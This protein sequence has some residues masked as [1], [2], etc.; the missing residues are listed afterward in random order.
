MKTYGWIAFLSAI[1]SILL[2]GL[3]HILSPEFDPSWRM[4][5][6]YANGN[7][8]GVLV[9]FF[10]LWGVSS[11]ALVAALRTQ[12]QSRG[13][14][15]GLVL[16]TIAGIGQVLAAIFDINHPLH[17]GVGNLAIP[18]FAIATILITK[19]LKKVNGWKE[20]ARRLAVLSHASWISVILLVAS[21]V[22]LIGTFAASGA[23]VDANA[24]VTVL[25]E[26]VVALVGWTNR[27]LVLV[28][29]AWTAVAAY[30]VIK[31]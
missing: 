3:L 1:I 14:K 24:A 25:P 5:S 18:A 4:V 31:K 16:L 7:F 26:G 15:V 13:G 29:A 19:S 28:F 8:G 6:E 27:L 21:F 23:T 30:S 17:D 9:G 20:S 22:V 2:L 12:V 10:A 11:L